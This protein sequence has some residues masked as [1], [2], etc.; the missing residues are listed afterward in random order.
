MAFLR[1][2]ATRRHIILLAFI[3]L[4][5]PPPSTSN[6]CFPPF[7][8]Y[9]SFG[10]RQRRNSHNARSK[11]DEFCATKMVQIYSTLLLLRFQ[12]IS[13]QHARVHCYIYT[14]KHARARDK[15]ARCA[16]IFQ[17][18]HRH[19][20]TVKTTFFFF[21]MVTISFRHH[22]RIEF[23]LIHYPRPSSSLPL[24]FYAPFPLSFAS[25]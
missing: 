17:P 19:S 11:I 10:A 1:A 6:F 9:L 3:V 25:W 18:R 12:S 20:R 7:S 2:P 8:Y 21:A 22:L 4:P 5:T 14:H 13:Q 16:K 23:T 15:G 24:F